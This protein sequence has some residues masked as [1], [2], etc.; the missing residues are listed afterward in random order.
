MTDAYYANDLTL[1]AI[2]PAQAK[3]RLNSLGQLASECTQI[4]QRTYAS[5]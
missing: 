4:K 5:N 1:L 3:T 2:T